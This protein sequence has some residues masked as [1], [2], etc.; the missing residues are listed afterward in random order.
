MRAALLGVVLQLTAS[1][2]VA[3]AL[4]VCWS[5]DGHVAIESGDCCPGGPL[6]SRGDALRAARACDG[7][8]DTPLLEAGL[9]G[10]GKPGVAVLSASS[11]DVVAPLD[12]RSAHPAGPRS[13]AGFP[14]SRRSVVLL[15]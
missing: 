5:I 3:S 7:C 12:V 9:S 6:E 4:V 13:S 11:W 10:S 1:V 2:G 14:R 15:I 8:V